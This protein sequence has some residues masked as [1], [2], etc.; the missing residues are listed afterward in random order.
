MLIKDLEEQSN[1]IGLLDDMDTMYLA[2]NG[3]QPPEDLVPDPD[4]K[5][6]Q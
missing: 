5:P 3:M 1:L 6:G 2:E 4:T